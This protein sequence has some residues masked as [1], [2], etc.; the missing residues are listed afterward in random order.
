MYLKFNRTEPFGA[1]FHEKGSTFFVF[2]ERSVQYALLFETFHLVHHDMDSATTVYLLTD[3]LT[4]AGS[5]AWEGVL[6]A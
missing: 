3:K 5:Q 2:M 4:E 6:N 1:V